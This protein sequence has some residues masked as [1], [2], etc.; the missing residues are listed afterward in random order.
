M[1]C[2]SCVFHL[3]FLQGH[4]S[5]KNIHWIGTC[6]WTAM[7][8]ICRDQGSY[9]PVVISSISKPAARLGCF[10]TLLGTISEFIPI[11]T[12]PLKCLQ[13]AL[14]PV[15]NNLIKA[16]REVNEAWQDWKKNSI[17]TSLPSVY[18]VSNAELWPRKSHELLPQFNNMYSTKISRFC[19]VLFDSPLLHI[20]PWK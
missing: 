14:I 17:S 3:L 5:F 11:H 20:L 13:I 7:T 1:W 16:C 12:T 9:L 19:I 6:L 10:H 18:V 4:C 2:F 15:N 8:E